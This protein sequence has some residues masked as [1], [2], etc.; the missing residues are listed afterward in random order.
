MRAKSRRPLAG[1]VDA[2]IETPPLANGDI[3]LLYTDGLPEAMNAEKELFGEERM[4]NLL[5]GLQERSPKEIVQQ[6]VRAVTEWTKAE[7]FED[8]LTLVVVKGT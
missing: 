5:A 1:A 7:T 6:L 4:K 2:E 8:D 3:L